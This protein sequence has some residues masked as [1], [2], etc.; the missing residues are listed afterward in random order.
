MTDSVYTTDTALEALA[1]QLECLRRMSRQER[2]RKM[3]AMS[4]QVRIMAFD[5]IRRRHPSLDESE[6]QLLFI[7]LTYG[8]PLADDVGR[9]KTEP[10]L[11]SKPS[12]IRTLH[13]ILPRSES[14]F[15]RKISAVSR[16]A[17]ALDGLRCRFFHGVVRV[18]VAILIG[19]MVGNASDVGHLNAAD[20]DSLL[21]ALPRVEADANKQVNLCLEQLKQTEDFS[22]RTQYLRQLF[23]NE[24]VVQQRADDLYPLVER[25]IR[26]VSSDQRASLAYVVAQYPSLHEL[27]VSQA[28]D[29]RNKDQVRLALVRSVS[30]YP[31][32]R[33]F[34]EAIQSPTHKR[35][36]L[37]VLVRKAPSLK[38]KLKHLNELT[39]LPNLDSWAYS[40]YYELRPFAAEFPDDIC[41][42]VIT[43]IPLEHRVGILQ[44]LAM[45]VID[46]D[47]EAAARYIAVAWREVSS[48]PRPWEPAAHL[49]RGDPATKNRADWLAKF[50]QFVLPALIDA[51]CGIDPLADLIRFDLDLL[52]DR[53]EKS[54]KHP[55]RSV[56][57]IFPSVIERAFGIKPEVV[58]DW[59]EDEHM[60]MPRKVTGEVSLR[61]RCVFEISEFV[62]V[63]SNLANPKYRDDLQRLCDVAL[64]IDCHELRLAT[65]AA[66]STELPRLN[67]E[68]PLAVIKE[69]RRLLD[70][71]FCPT[72]QNLSVQEVSYFYLL[73]ANQQVGCIERLF[74]KLEKQTSGDFSSEAGRMM[75]LIQAGRFSEDQR[76]RWYERLTRT[77]TDRK[78]RRVPAEIAKVVVRT[79][80]DW[81]I[82]TIWALLPADRGRSGKPAGNIGWTPTPSDAADAV[83]WLEMGVPDSTSEREAQLEFIAAL[84]RYLPSMTESDRDPTR[85][86]IAQRLARLRFHDNA[87][88]IIETIESS[89]LRSDARFDWVANH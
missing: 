68:V 41:E 17:G 45:M 85:V 75:E 61:S 5:T 12:K 63:Y 38:E 88:G 22:K 35:Y 69:G 15:R 30:E 40:N 82:R 86:A 78:E 8:Q 58:L 55:A 31:V 62:S 24:A 84:Y 33:R 48:H 50:D 66:L 7:E 71:D 89:H 51:K 80:P 1:V 57:S 25:T 81:A 54:C 44:H 64:K 11:N 23:L 21:Q 2:I 4:R 60:R 73:E 19:W 14:H 28:E 59:L 83:R 49:L 39:S 43:N 77:A 27:L 79:N 42:S 46:T 72:L 56:D 32:A 9:W 29:P 10:S 16:V 87:L 26:E 70:D 13:D 18:A 6:V 47:D 20:A 52:I 65:L 36:A 3:C 74:V 34:T 37:E 67:F 53:T 76:L